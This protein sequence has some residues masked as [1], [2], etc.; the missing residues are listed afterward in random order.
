MGEVYGKQGVDPTLAPVDAGTYYEGQLVKA[1]GTAPRVGLTT[2]D[3]DE[4]IGIVNETLANAR[5]G[6]A[7]ALAAGY[8]IGIYEL[9]CKET[10]YVKMIA[11]QAL[12]PGDMIYAADGT[13][14]Y[15]TRVSGSSQARPIGH[16]PRQGFPAIASTTAG[17][18][19]PCR[20]DV[21]I[22][23]ALV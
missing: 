1:S 13:D 16:Y 3:G 15:A 22:G 5:D 9:D 11:S 23:T 18:L 4:V 21:A 6:S 20:L 2:E 14:G 17:Q 7:R 12:N 8:R 10:V 19:V